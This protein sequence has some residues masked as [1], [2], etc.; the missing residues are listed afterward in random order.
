MKIRF[1]LLPALIAAFASCSQPGEQKTAEQKEY[2]E[3]QKASWFL[4]NWENNFPEGRATESWTQANDSTYTGSS[5]VVIGKDTVSSETIRLEERT[6]KLLYIPTVSDQ[7]KGKEV[8]FTMT[9]S[10]SKKLVF[11]NPG[12]DFPQKITYTKIGKDSLVAEISGRMDGKL[13]TEPFPMSRAK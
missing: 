10:S 3:L 1:Y 2:T 9:S 11:E 12:H 6:G 13:H 8:V 7:N 5:F 4:G